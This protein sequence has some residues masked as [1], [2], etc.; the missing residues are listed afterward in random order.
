MPTTREDLSEWFDRGAQKGAS[1]MVVVVDTF[2][3]EDYPV[4]C[5]TKKEALIRMKDPG[6]MQR[7]MEVYDL[8]ADK[9][10]QLNQYRSFALTHQEALDM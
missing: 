5:D 2:D 3:Y 6:E 10:T 1:Y 7:V 9:E 8:K 4:F